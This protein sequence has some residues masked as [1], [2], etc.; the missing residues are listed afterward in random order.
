MVKKSS[1]VDTF[2]TRL[3]GEINYPAIS[4]VIRD[5]D[6]ANSDKK[7]QRIIL[8]VISHGGDLF[9]GFALFDHIKASPK[10]VDIIA[11]GVC[12]SA[13]VMVLQAGRVRI[14]RPHTLFMVHPSITYV[15]E[16]AY[17]EFLSIVDQYKKNHDL[18]VRLTI[19]RSGMD[20]QEFERIYNPRK[21]LTPV[22]A[23]EFGT[24]GLIDIVEEDTTVPIHSNGVRSAIRL[25]KAG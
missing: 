12:M 9:S 1:G 19:G 25:G 2:Y 20:R 13:A 5:I 7:I 3:I 15:E 22:E 21:Y 14:A 4:D 17:N 11:E 24:N 16:K 10:A 8:T 18:F 6:S 23:K